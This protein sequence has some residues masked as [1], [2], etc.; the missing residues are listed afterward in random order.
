MAADIRQIQDNG[1]TERSKLVGRADAGQHKEARR[2]NCA[3]TKQDLSIGSYDVF[4]KSQ[5][6][7]PSAFDNKAEHFR[8]HQQINGH[9]PEAPEISRRRIVANPSLDTEL[10]P[11][12]ARRDLSSDVGRH[13][14]SQVL[15]RLYESGCHGS[16]IRDVRE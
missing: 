9:A 7:A 16:A 4:G 11:T 15:R 2:V 1:N 10:I 13:R 6:D 12:D 8:V 14:E 3:S 5:A